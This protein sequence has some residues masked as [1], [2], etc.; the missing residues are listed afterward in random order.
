MS[1]TAQFPGLLD[2]IMTARRHHYVPQCYLKGFVRDRI[3]PKLFVID[4]KEHR[5]FSTAPANVAAERDFHR[6]KIE[7]YE[8]D[9]LEKAFS[10][11]SQALDRIIAARSISNEDDRAYLLNLMAI[12]SVKNPRHRESFRHFQERL[13]KQVLDVA[14]GTPEMWASQIRRAKAS[15]D[16]EPDAD[17]VYNTMRAFVEAD[18]HKIEIPTGRHLEN[19]IESFEAVLPCFFQRHWVLLKAP[20][21]Q[22][23]FI[24]SDHPVCLMWFDPARRG[25]FKGPGHGRRGTRIIFPISNELAVIGEFETCDNELDVGLP[26]VAL[27]NAT[28]LLY[29]D[30]QIYAR[31]GHFVYKLEHHSR[32][33]RGFE[34][35]RDRATLPPQGPAT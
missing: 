35:L 20:R 14:T 26:F 6:I 34:L 25:R 8:P 7:G 23:G 16:I 24:T 9:V 1:V 33:M 13:W 32:T 29:A 18:Q 5:S 22:S 10:E 4:G 12:L 19:E 2:K 30:R 31:D 11:V 28:I 27:V 21:R 17:T 3:R 15:G